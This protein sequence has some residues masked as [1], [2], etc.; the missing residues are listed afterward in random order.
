MT[1]AAACSLDRAAIEAH[2][3][4]KLRALLTALLAGNRFYAD[5]L[6]AAGFVTGPADLREFVR[7]VPFTS[8]PELVQ[9]QA[10]NPPYGSNL[11]HDLVRY[12]RFNQTSG[13]AGR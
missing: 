13:T 10:R 11:T 4:D 12:S 3:V 5:K 9:D 2:Q 6:R 8:K 7:V 1:P